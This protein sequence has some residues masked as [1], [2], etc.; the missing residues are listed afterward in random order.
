M[1]R[2]RITWAIIALFS[3]AVLASFVLTV[4]LTLESIKVDQLEGIAKKQGWMGIEETNKNL[5]VAN[6]F[7]SLRTIVANNGELNI[8]ALVDW[9]F[10]FTSAPPTPWKLLAIY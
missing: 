10:L 3:L 4:I 9:N 2:S 8:V 1:G 7:R 6:F 5:C